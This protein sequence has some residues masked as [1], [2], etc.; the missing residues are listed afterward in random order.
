MLRSLLAISA[1]NQYL[2]KFIGF[3]KYKARVPS[4]IILD[5][6]IEREEKTIALITKIPK[7]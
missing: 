4:E 3:N 1:L 5:N 2:K 7:T 6:S